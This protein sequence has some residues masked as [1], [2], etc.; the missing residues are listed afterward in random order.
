MEVVKQNTK[1]VYD[2]GNLSVGSY[3]SQ[4]E[5]AAVVAGTPAADAE[6]D[7]SKACCAVSSSHY[8]KFELVDSPV[9]PYMCTGAP[10][11]YLLRHFTFNVDS[12]VRFRE[13]AEAASC[14]MKANQSTGESATCTVNA[15]AVLEG[16]TASPPYTLP[17][18][19]Y[20]LCR[21]GNSLTSAESRSS[22]IPVI[23]SSFC[24]GNQCIS[25]TPAN[26]RRDRSACMN[27][28]LG[29]YTSAD[30]NNTS[31]FSSFEKDGAA[32]WPNLFKGCKWI[33]DITMSSPTTIHDI[34]FQCDVPKSTGWSLS[35]ENF[36]AYLTDTIAPLFPI[37]RPTRVAGQYVSPTDTDT[38]LVEVEYVSFSSFKTGMWTLR[39]CATRQCITRTFPVAGDTGHYPSVMR[40]NVS[41]SRLGLSTSPYGPLMV[42]D[43][44]SAITPITSPF[45]TL[46][47]PSVVYVE[48]AVT[49]S[50]QDTVNM[51]LARDPPER[52][53]SPYAAST[54]GKT[55]SRVLCEGDYRFSTATNDCQP[56][57]DRDC[58]TKYRGRRSRF[59]PAARACAYPVPLLKGPLLFKPL[60]DP[61]PPRV[62]S[63]EELRDI[64]RTVRLP[65]F[66]RTMEKSYAEYE[67]QRAQREGRLVRPPSRQAEPA[68][69]TDVAAAAVA[70]EPRRAYTDGTKVPGARGLTIT[71]I[72]TTCVLWTVALLR[73]VLSKCFAVG[74][75]DGER[76][77]A[78]VEGAMHC[79]RWLS[80]AGAEGH[81]R[82][83][84][85]QQGNASSAA[86]PPTTAWASASQSTTQE[87]WSGGRAGPA[88]KKRKGKGTSF[89]AATSSPSTVTAPHEA[90][91]EP[92]SSAPFK[93]KSPEAAPQ[94]ERQGGGQRGRRPRAYHSRGTE[95][96]HW[97]GVPAAEGG[98]PLHGLTNA[99]STS[100]RTSQLTASSAPRKR[101]TLR[102]AAGRGLSPR[103]ACLSRVAATW[104]TASA[105]LLRA[106]T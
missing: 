105:S 52:V 31:Q 54:S 103:V 34:S 59:D 46:L 18:R 94:H 89:M 36:S 76:P 77:C 84:P 30:G 78:F 2:V 93:A 74:P 83:R 26:Y 44:Y 45:R 23:A 25:Y 29:F 42:I 96:E 85:R 95:Q 49:P 40:V 14:E 60:T 12:T 56:L 21:Q 13:A 67:R 81:K 15:S 5:S 72:V 97:Q 51:T 102:L 39:I 86:A 33:D 41:A 10:I 75:W 98:R 1:Y 4:S 16:V 38:I 57:T 20:A 63:P 88:P 61:G 24:S 92:V 27:Y 50:S 22:P 9:P 69:G 80:R 8:R 65:Q 71:C 66:L 7:A 43:A 100:Q 106:Q 82:Q 48:K 32:L 99:P 101:H 35:Y 73:N 87:N 70:E 79:W 55:T 28:P 91:G 17:S 64:L 58:A 37:G 3:Q 6:C 68:E 90:P 62:Y 47:A 19:G 53:P 104:D 11:P